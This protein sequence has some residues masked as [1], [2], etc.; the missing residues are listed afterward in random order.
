[1]I[2]QQQQQTN[3]WVLSS[4]QLNLVIFFKE[5]QINALFKNNIWLKKY[6]HHDLKYYLHSKDL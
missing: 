1:M 4:V 5:P 3:Q 2:Q 6:S